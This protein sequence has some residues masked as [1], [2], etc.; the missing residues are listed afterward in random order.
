[1]EHTKDIF[2]KCT[3]SVKTNET[4][5]TVHLAEPNTIFQQ[6]YSIDTQWYTKK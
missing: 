2:P 3:T 4:G 5:N 6:K 1:M